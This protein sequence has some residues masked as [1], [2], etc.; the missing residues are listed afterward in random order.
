[1]VIWLRVRVLPVACTL[2]MQGSSCVLSI[3]RCH[4]EETAGRLR[5]IFVDK[6]Y[7]RGICGMGIG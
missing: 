5:G 7:R 6:T 1:M 2:V 4:W 3:G